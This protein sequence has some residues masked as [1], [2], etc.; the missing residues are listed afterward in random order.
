M[1]FELNISE[2]HRNAELTHCLKTASGFG[3]T[4]AAVILSKEATTKT[5][6]SDK[7]DIIE[8]SSVEITK[9]DSPFAEYIRSEYKSLEDANMKFFKMDNLSKLGYIASCK[10]FKT[11]SYDYP[12]NRIGIVLANRN[13]SLNTDL[14]HQKIVDQHLPEG[15]SPAVFVYTLANI[16]ASE[17]A[18]K[19]KLQGETMMFVSEHKDMEYLKRYSEQLIQDDRCDAVIYGWCDLL[20]E[21]YNAELKL[22]KRK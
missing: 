11:V 2:K 5:K 14:A 6:Q 19:H 7:V 20:E 1:S 4:N 22:V 17:I 21:E 15:S 10:L 12:H 9:S 13:S 8:V 18:I 3:G 16:V